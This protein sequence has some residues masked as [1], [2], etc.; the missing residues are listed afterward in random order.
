LT[1]KQHFITL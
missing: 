1:C